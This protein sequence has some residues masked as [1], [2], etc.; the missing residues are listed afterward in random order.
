MILTVNDFKCEARIAG[1]HNIIGNFDTANTEAQRV[2]EAFISKYE[3]VFLLKF[4]DGDRDRISEIEH[5]SSLPDEERTDDEK[6]ALLNCLVRSIS[7]YVA[8]YYFRNSTI[9]ITRIG[10]V[11]P[12]GENGRRVNTSSVTCL[13]WNQMAENNLHIYEDVLKE[14][15][16]DTEVFVRVNEFNL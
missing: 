1:L 10:G 13:L 14:K 15:A 3:P 11:I 12:Q 5:Y 7:H 2:V 16:P 6:N 4:F 9:E 8:F